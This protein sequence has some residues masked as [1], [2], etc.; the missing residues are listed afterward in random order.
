MRT[1]GLT[2]TLFGILGVLSNAENYFSWSQHFRN[3]TGNIWSTVTRVY[4]TVFLTLTAV[5][6]LNSEDLLQ[7]MFCTH[8]RQ[9]CD[10]R[11]ANASCLPLALCSIVLHFN[12]TATPLSPYFSCLFLFSCTSKNL[13]QRNCN[14]SIHFFLLQNNQILLQ[15]FRFSATN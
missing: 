3:L 4:C 11:N 13:V 8:M 1:S 5:K 14:G 2:T 15:H 7:Y 9:C 12:C 10:V 6:I